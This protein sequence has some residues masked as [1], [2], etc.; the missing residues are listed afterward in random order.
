MILLNIDW[1][2]LFLGDNDF[3][4]LLEIGIRTI[5][6]YLIILVGLKLLGKRGVSQLSVFE[7]VVII[8]LGSA[9]G[10]PMFYKEVGLMVPL[11]VFTIVVVAYR[12]TIYAMA[13]NDKFETLIEGKPTYLIKDGQFAIG[14]FKK[15]Q[16]AKD[17]FFSELR[18]NSIS[19]L[20]QIDM[21]ILE[22]SG[23]LSVYYYEDN[24][25][26]FGLPILPSLFKEQFEQITEF[27]TYACSFCGHVADLHPAQECVCIRCKKTH[28]VTAIDSK[29][30]K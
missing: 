25:V 18:N 3:D 23:R 8:G 15:E 30:V 20:G 6:M 2:K 21:A 29:R 14:H 22:T 12:L 27:A 9:A 16:L 26:K 28:W 13:K 1:T 4:F 7:L 17:E 11:A 10:D 24:M 5:V 19:H